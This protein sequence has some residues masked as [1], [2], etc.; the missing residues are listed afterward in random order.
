MTD[1]FPDPEVVPQPV[2]LPEEGAN[3]F[4][5]ASLEAEERGDYDAALERVGAYQAA[6]GDGFLARLR[7]AWLY[8]LK[9]EFVKAE[10]FCRAAEE[11]IPDRAR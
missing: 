9:G 3:G 1:I 4:W 5:S 6:G 8:S 2:A 11:W 10:A 7:T